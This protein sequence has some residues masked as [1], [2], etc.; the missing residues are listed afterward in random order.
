MAFLENIIKSHRTVLYVALPLW[1][2][3]NNLASGA[4]PG[5][6]P[7]DL[8]FSMLSGFIFF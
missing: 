7:P 1:Y 2:F 8:G 3:Q 6:F 4:K 5:V